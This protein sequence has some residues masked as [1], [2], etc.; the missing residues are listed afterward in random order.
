[1]YSK[2]ETNQRWA[3][4][5]V[6]FVVLKEYL[7]VGMEAAYAIETVESLRMRRRKVAGFVIV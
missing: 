3:A 4:G 2:S 6:D 5:I 7:Q 1:M